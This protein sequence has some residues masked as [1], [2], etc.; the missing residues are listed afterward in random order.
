MDDGLRQVF[1]LRVYFQQITD[2]GRG[3]ETKRQPSSASGSGFDGSH[4]VDSGDIDNIPT[5]GFSTL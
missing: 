2:K 1:L 4:G 3:V 5:I